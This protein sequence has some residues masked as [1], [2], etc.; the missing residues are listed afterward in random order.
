M[1][2]PPVF[3]LSCEELAERHALCHAHL[4]SN[5]IKPHYWWGFHGNTWGVGTYQEYD[6]GKSLPPGHVGLNMGWWAMLQHAGAMLDTMSYDEGQECIIFEDDVQLP[7]DF[8]KQFKD[9]KKKLVQHIPN[10][11]LVFLG[12]AATEPHVW[13]RVTERIGLGDTGLCRLNDPFGTHALLIRRRAIP[14]LLEHMRKTERNLDQQL[15]KYVLSP[16]H[17]NWCAVLPSIVRQRTF[18]YAGSGTPEWAPSTIEVSALA[19]LPAVVPEPKQPMAMD[20]LTGPQVEYFQSVVDPYPC[21]YRGESLDEVDRVVGIK[22]PVPIWDCNRLQKKCHTKDGANSENGAV[23]CR[24]CHIRSAMPVRAQHTDRL[25]LPEGHFNPSLIEY[26]GRLILATRDSWGHSKVGLWE[27]SGA[28]VP[29]PISSI[30]STHPEATRLEDP[31]LF[32]APGTSGQ[33]RLHAMFNLPDGYPAKKVQVGYVEFSDDL[34]SIVRTKVFKSPGNRSVYEKN[35]VPFY[36]DLTGQVHWVY[37]TVPEHTVIS[38]TGTPIITDNP[39]P[40]KGGALRGGACPQLHTW[41]GKPAFYHFFHG[42]IKR[43]QGSVYTVGCCV[44][45]A[46][47]P[48]RVLAQTST[49][50]IWPDLPAIGESVVKRYVVWPGGAVRRNGHWLL[51]LGID[52]TFCRLVRLTDGEL[53]PNLNTVPEEASSLGIRDTVLVTG[54][55]DS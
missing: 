10:Y 50:L 26:N 18:D 21:I 47:P 8:E 43:L 12:M 37:Q 32:I 27:L 11:D 36:S 33:L 53:I 4:R 6:K 19:R 42:C 22:M 29:K 2:L 35:W 54:Q 7:D 46:R 1:S 20:D 49:P 16:G 5:N 39:L 24:D 28:D 51:A 44:F 48:F 9:L 45:D 38:E 52:D 55:R 17:L 41:Q 31:R 14:T 25:D 34:Q 40:W 13:H 23:A 30:P 3:V 15:W